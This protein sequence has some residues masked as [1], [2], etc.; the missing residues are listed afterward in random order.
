MRAVITLTPSESKRLIAKAVAC[1]PE[2]KKAMEHAYV[3]VADGTTNALVW[4]ELTGDKSLSPE[5]FTIGIHTK[6]VLCVSDITKRQ[7][8]SSVLYKGEEMPRKSFAEALQDYHKDT[9]VIKGANAVDE[10]GFVGI[11]ASG[12]DGGTVAKVIGPVTSKGILMITPVGLEKLIPSV[13]AAAKAMCG[14]GN[15]DISMGAD[16]GMY[17]L[18]NTMIVTEIEALR[19]LF[20]V[21]ATL[22]CRGGVGGNEGAVTLSVIGEEDKVTEMV[23]YLEAN[24]KGEPA[25]KGSK[26]KCETCR[27]K[28]CRYQGKKLEELPK[29]L[30]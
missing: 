21:E 28:N 8:F 26:G 20:G 14:G 16:A 12:F 25:I 5:N 30:R 23:E 1:L 11:I 2:V 19:L 17:C 6:G 15:I 22:V 7:R 27:Y 3:L 18:N 24:V 10:D 13:P 29:W 4:Q 9:V